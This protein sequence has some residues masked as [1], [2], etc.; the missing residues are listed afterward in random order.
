MKRLTMIGLL[1]SAV[2]WSQTPAASKTTAPEFRPPDESALPDNEFG[3]MVRLG[4]DIFVNTGEHAKAYVGNGLRCVNCHLD[5]GRH[6]NSA[7]LWAAYVLYPA[8]RSK[9][10]KVD[11]LQNRIEGCFQYSMN[12][13]APPQNSEI[14]TALVTYHYWLAQGAPTGVE[15]KGRGYPELPK[16]ASP[17]TWER[18]EQVYQNNCAIC[19][20]VDGKGQKSGKRYVFPPL[21]GSQSYNW[22]A[23]MHRLNTAAAFIKANMPLGVG[24]TLSDQ[25]AW[26]VAYYIN[27]QDRPRDPR[28]KGKLQVTDKTFH[29]EN[30]L[31]GEK[32]RGRLLR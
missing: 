8:Y 17:P 18:G 21:W 14:M 11:T 23:G 10:N 28:D 29:D 1:T 12:G 6:P 32:I 19:H 5:R 3:R 9:T 30:C 7:P 20:G 24:G 31:Y 2:G 13:K 15:L 22:G 4:R 25:Q 26:D 16:P 27:A